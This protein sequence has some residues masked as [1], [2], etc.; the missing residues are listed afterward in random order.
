MFSND[1]IIRMAG[2]VTYE[3]GRQLYDAGYVLDMDVQTAGDYDEIVAS[4]RGSGA[5]VYETDLLILRETGE[6]EECYCECPAFRS[7]DGICKHCVAVWLQ[8]RA[9]E[10]YEEEEDGQLT[11]DSIPGVTRGFQRHTSPELA[12]LFQRQ[13]LKKSLPVLQNDTYGKVKLEPE[14]TFDGYRFLVSF[15]V[16]VSRMYVLKDVLDFICA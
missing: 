16:G 8:Y 10:G 9:E 12:A 3:R 14:F 15:K 4:V 11:L 13:A 6:L 7:Y 1:D 2:R 5:K